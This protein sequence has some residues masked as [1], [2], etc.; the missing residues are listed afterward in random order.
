MSSLRQASNGGV[1]PER[2]STLST[3][4]V[5]LE[6]SDPE[7]EPVEKKIEG[8]YPFDQRKY[9]GTVFYQEN[10]DVSVDLSPESYPFRYRSGSGLFIIEGDIPAVKIRE[11]F[12]ELN[13]RLVE[14]SDDQLI[15]VGSTRL[16]E[17][18]FVFAS[19]DWP[20]IV[21]TD[22]YGEEVSIEELEDLSKRE[23]AHNYSL[24]RARVVF[25]Y[26]GE[27][28]NVSYEDGILNFL[29]DTSSEGR[30]YVIQQFEK[31]VVAGQILEEIS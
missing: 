30:E 29:D 7:G 28:I 17:W 9:S 23:I 21:P 24:D 12:A 14:L 16:G 27:R 18:S 3:D 13:S 31:Y 4:S 19:R 25:Y 8:D 5:W 6:L 26:D 15:S 22:V 20:Q 10:F 1:L 2:L 11:I